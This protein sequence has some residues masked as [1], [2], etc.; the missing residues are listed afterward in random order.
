MSKSVIVAAA[1]SLGLTSAA[2][3]Q[4]NP[5]GPQGS[6]QS[7]VKTPKSGGSEVSPGPG[8]LPGKSTTSVMPDERP[9][10]VNEAGDAR[11]NEK[12]TRSTAPAGSASAPNPKTPSDVKEAGDARPMDRQQGGTTGTTGSGTRSDSSKRY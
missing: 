4:T 12:T 11:P 7:G 3:A 9:K 10:S 2:W 5:A 6:T 1:L 8:P